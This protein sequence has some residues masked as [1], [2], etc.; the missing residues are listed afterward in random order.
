M[1]KIV[2]GLSLV[3][4]LAVAQGAPAKL[5]WP[6][7]FTG[8]PDFAFTR[9]EAFA[10]ARAR[11]VRDNLTPPVFPTLRMVATDETTPD[12]LRL[13]MQATSPTFNE[14]G[15]AISGTVVSGSISLLDKLLS[16]MQGLPSYATP[17]TVQTDEYLG[18]MQSLISATVANWQP[19]PNRYD[20]SAAVESLVLQAVVTS[21]QQ[22]AVINGTRYTVGSSFLLRVPLM[23][24]DIEIMNALQA[25]APDEV[26]LDDAT[27]ATYAEVREAVLAAFAAARNL[28]PRLGQKVLNIPVMVERIEPRRVMLNINGQQKPLAVRYAF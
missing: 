12:P 2:L 9:D 4:G 16:N 7:S 15:E 19:D 17:S 14:L 25:A 22:Y 23:V 27:L 24:P 6:R 26:G 13:S 10:E 1:I 18:T 21:P 3:A 5:T 28:N 20:F 8:Q 11:A